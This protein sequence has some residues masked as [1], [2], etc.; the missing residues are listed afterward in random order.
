MR[1]RSDFITNSS[2]ASFVITRCELTE[3]QIEK[4]YNHIEVAKE[5]DKCTKREH[6]LYH[7]VG[8]ECPCDKKYYTSSGDQ[9]D[10]EEA[11]GKLLIG[12]TWMDNFGMRMFLDEIGVPRSMVSWSED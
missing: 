6:R 12:T 4:I 8:S 2:S 3:E 10:I 1:I 7:A 5:L 9:W 11:G